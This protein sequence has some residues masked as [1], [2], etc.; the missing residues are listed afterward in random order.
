[1][2]S[3][4]IETRLPVLIRRWLALN[5]LLLTLVGILSLTYPVEE[6]SRRLGDGFFR[7]R[8]HEPTSNSVAMVLI[9]DTSL[10]RYGRWPWPRTE[11]ANL[12]TTVSRQHPASIGLDI[13]LS[14]SGDQ[15]D[16]NL[17]QAIRDAGN[18]V[19]AAKLST[20]PDRL[21]ED[22]LPL[23][24]AHAAGLGHVQ[25]IM[26]PDGIGRCVPLAEVSADGT[27][28]PLAVE[29]A[30]VATGNPIRVDG[31]TLWLGNTPIGVE[32]QPQRGQGPGWSSY[33]P[34]FLYIDFRQQFVAG[35]ADPPFIT[36]SAASVLRGQSP[37]SLR[38]KNVLIGFGASD[39][40]D[41]IPTPVS[42]QIPMPGVELHA[43]L[44][45]GL[46]TGQ[47]IRHAAVGPQILLVI[48]YSLASTWFVLR[49]PGWESVWIPGLRLSRTPRRSL[50]AR[51][52]C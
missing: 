7:L 52:V 21:W 38:G 48:V 34:Q 35:E 23:F 25:A 42:G 2:S 27:R 31:G 18:V 14:E 19:L 46:L 3:P 41:R 9:D 12:I 24:R 33:S 11:L 26:D 1:M 8:G 49:R 13:L 43:N 47:G 22:P 28:W 30:R 15:S 20:S 50:L 32:G 17:A 36:I 39:L 16:D 5:L 45:D 10:D 44:L 37:Q 40:G 29:M 4:R 6:L 51:P